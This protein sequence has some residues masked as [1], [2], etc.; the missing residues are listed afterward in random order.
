[1]KN[2]LLLVWLLLLTV[3]WMLVIFGF[4]A[5]S[6][7]ESSGM[8]AIISKPLTGLV[9]RFTGD[10]ASEED[11]FLKVDLAVRKTAHFTEYTILGGLLML[12]FRC[13]RMRTI[14]L[15]VLCGTLYAVTDEWHQSFSPG[16]SS[17][18]MDVLIDSCGVLIGAFL[19]AAILY[20]WRKKH[21]Q[22]S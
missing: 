17:A 22:D 18:W 6:G 10:S 20:L 11:I 12:L 21:V 4:S 5:Q 3:G 13:L 14:C 2:K 7:T 1:M 16:R 15:P 8:S 9:M 19:C